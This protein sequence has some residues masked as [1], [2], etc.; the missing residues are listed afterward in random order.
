MFVFDKFMYMLCTVILLQD[1]VC[2]TECVLPFLVIF[3]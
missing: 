3:V 1:L 2:A